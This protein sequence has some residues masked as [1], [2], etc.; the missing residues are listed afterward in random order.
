MAPSRGA[1][2]DRTA[3]LQDQTEELISLPGIAS[4]IFAINSLSRV[5]GLLFFYILFFL[6]LRFT[7]VPVA[8]W[9]FLINAT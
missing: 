4:Y 7:F 8:V 5:V 9:L 2:M 3:V 6:S 1:V